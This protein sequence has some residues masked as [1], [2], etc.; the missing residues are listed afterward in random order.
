MQQIYDQFLNRV[1]V[2]PYT[3][4]PKDTRKYH[5]ARFERRLRFTAQL[6]DWNSQFNPL[7]K[8]KIAGVPETLAPVR[9]RAAGRRTEK[10]VGVRPA[11]TPKTI[12]SSVAEYPERDFEDAEDM[13]ENA[14]IGTEKDGIK[15]GQRNQ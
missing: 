5:D 4:R 13:M 14:E 2:V 10:R 11:V 6:I 3:R 8:Q 1:V 15:H 12:R 9:H 7:D